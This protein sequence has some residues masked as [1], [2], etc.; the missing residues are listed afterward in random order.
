MDRPSDESGHFAG[1]RQLLISTAPVGFVAV[2]YM[3][4]N[5]RHSTIDNAD[6]SAYKRIGS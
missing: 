4:D 3:H 6:S 2:L 5:R 1:I